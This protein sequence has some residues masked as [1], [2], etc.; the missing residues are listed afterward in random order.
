MST[1][2]PPELSPPEEELS[3]EEQAQ[4]EVIRSGQ[5][6]VVVP[7][8]LLKES[9][10]SAKSQSMAELIRAMKGP[11]KIKLAMFGNRTVRSLLI[12]DS[13]RQIPLFVLQNAK[14]TEDEV[15]EF[16]RNSNLDESVLREIA[17]NP[18]WMKSYQIK[19]NIVSNPR[20]PLDLSLRWL[21]FIQERDLRILS[22]SKNVPS[23][24]A[25]QSRK[26]LE[27]REK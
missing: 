2:D 18:Q 4:V 9:P 16:S 12:R 7:A 19:L 11:Q 23:V 5:D 6:A 27:K 24:I 26:L 8:E 25:N 14:L 20:V 21:K 17:N 1:D 3:F 13:I 22:R 15:A 10:D